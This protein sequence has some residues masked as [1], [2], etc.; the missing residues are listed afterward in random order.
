MTKIIDTPTSGTVQYAVHIRSGESLVA[1]TE[2]TTDQAAAQA[3]L[4][5]MRHAGYAESLLVLRTYTPDDCGSGKWSD[6]D[7]AT[8]EQLN[9]IAIQRAVTVLASIIRLDLPL[10]EW[11]VACEYEPGKLTAHLHVGD[12]DERLKTL[13]TYAK[14]LG[15][16]LVEDERS[17]LVRAEGT[18]DGV[19][20]RVAAYIRRVDEA[21]QVTAVTA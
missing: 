18:Y 12:V 9:R 15:A 16:D 3:L 4:P 6:W 11:S 1:R 20:V 2:P 14:L 19:G 7:P 10:V 21:E 8:D 17:N 13:T 5:R